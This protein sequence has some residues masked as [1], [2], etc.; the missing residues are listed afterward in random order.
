MGRV[1]DAR[2]PIDEVLLLVLGLPRRATQANLCGLEAGL[3]GRLLDDRVLAA[4]LWVLVV[5]HEATSFSRFPV[6]R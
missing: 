4:A 6:G 5:G 1:R 3:A 2:R